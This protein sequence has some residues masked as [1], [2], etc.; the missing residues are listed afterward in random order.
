MKKNE[1]RG[2]ITLAIILVVYS[3]IA[4]AVP[5]EK[6][7]TFW[8]AYL[9]G[10][11]AIAYQIYFFKIAF[12]GDG[13]VKSKFYGF[14]IAKIGVVYLVFQLLLSLVEI[15]LAEIIPTWVGIIINILPVAVASVGCIAADAMRDEIARQDV[16]LKMDVSNM[17]RMQ[18]FSATLME[19][20]S[21]ASLKEELQKLADAFRY[22]DPVSSN[23]TKELENDLNTSLNELQSVVSSGDVEGARTLCNKILSSL[24]E[25]NR[26][27][28]LNK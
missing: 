10:V 26:I 24:S 6:T 1:L 27:C 23:E 14:P 17:R 8:I 16:Q 3:V 5:F 28:A 15:C 12:T 18:S 20:C 2:Y 21:D 13:D 11:I 22:S 25:R 4:F 19:Q 7:A 9:F